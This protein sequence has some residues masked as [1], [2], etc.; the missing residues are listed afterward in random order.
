MSVVVR[1]VDSA[2]LGTPVVRWSMRTADNTESGERCSARAVPVISRQ[3]GLVQR[4]A[5][6]LGLC[7]KF[8]TLKGSNLSR[9][10]RVIRGARKSPIPPTSNPEHAWKALGLV[11]DWIRVADAKAAGT[12][13]A[14]GVSGGVLFNLVKDVRHPGVLL[15]IAASL[16]GTAVIFTGFC[17]TLVLWPRL[18]KRGNPTSLLYF[19]HVARGHPVHDTYVEQL[20]KLTT[21][22]DA[23]G[24]EIAQQ[25][26]AN[27]Q[28]ARRKYYWG[29]WA[30]RSLIMALAI[31]AATAIARV[32]S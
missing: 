12:L 20:L 23:L 9:P 26:W 24:S 18:G 2:T 31:L 3:A 15:V 21:D 29:G 22:L 28:V 6:C 13:A 16:C 5:L 19:D 4:L 8:D 10:S 30:I 1:K 32:L 14:A 7:V 17:C 27:S 25:S 11:V